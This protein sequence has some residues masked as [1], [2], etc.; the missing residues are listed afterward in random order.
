[1]GG[2]EAGGGRG[3][4]RGAAGRLELA[5]EAK[6]P[7]G[8]IVSLRVEESP[9]HELCEHALQ[10]RYLCPVCGEPFLE[11]LATVVPLG[12]AVRDAF[13]IHAETTHPEDA[14]MPA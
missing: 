6:A 8:L 12:E 5:G 4:A 11:F 9:G 3:D 1:M 10:C 14:E 2:R 7:G 13:V